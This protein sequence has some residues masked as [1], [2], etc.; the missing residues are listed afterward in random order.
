ML[1][2]YLSYFFFQIITTFFANNCQ[3]DDK[4]FHFDASNLNMKE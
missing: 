1:F 4:N 3:V 2:K